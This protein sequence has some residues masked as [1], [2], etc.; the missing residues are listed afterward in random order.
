MV[1][2]DGSRAPLDLD[3]LHTIVTEACTNLS[4]VSGA[5]IIDEALKNLYDGVTA[6]S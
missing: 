4:D 6:E 1:Q 3:R 2:A 5:E